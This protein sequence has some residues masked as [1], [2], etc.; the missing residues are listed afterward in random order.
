MQRRDVLFLLV[1]TAAAL[2]VHGYHPRAEDG[3]IYLPGVQKILNPQLFPFNAQFFES[4]AHLTF[5]PNL[6]A[7]SVRLTH[8]PLLYAL[9]FWHLISIFLLLFA[10]WELAQKVFRERI[11]CY[12]GVALVAALLTLP[13]AGS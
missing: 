12:A 1:M 8:L 9:F 11:A 2:F 5:F 4:H 13:V 6:I 10:C 3:A 7:A